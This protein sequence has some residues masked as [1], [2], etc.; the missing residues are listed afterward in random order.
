MAVVLGCSI[1]THSS[2]IKS[3]AIYIPGFQYLG[4]LL[5][6]HLE[7]SEIY[8]LLTAL[9][10]GVPV[11]TFPG[12]SKFDLDSIWTFLWGGSI[13]NQPAN[14]VSPRI[15]LCPEAVVVLL[16]MARSMIHCKDISVPEMLQNHPISIIQVL[17]QLYHNMPEFMPLFM[18][19]EVL[20]ALA[21]VLFPFSC[22]GSTDSS[23]AS[24]PAGDEN[25]TVLIVSRNIFEESPLT[26]HPV[27]QFI[28][29]FIRVVVVDSLSLSV[30]GKTAPVI[31]I[32]LDAFPE[33]STSSQQ[34]C[35]QTEILITLM[36]HLL[37]ADMLVGDQA[38]IPVVPLA[39]AHIQHVTPNVFYLTARIVDKLWQGSLT[40]DPHDVFDFI[41]KLIGQAKRRSSNLSLECLYH[42][43]NRTILFLLSRSSDNI[44]D[45]MSVLEALHKL[46]T[47][48]IIVFGAGNHEL[49]FI[50]C[51]TY[52]LLQ[53]TADMRI[54]LESNM[55]TTW[56]V[57]PSSDLESRD[58]HLNTHQGRNL[59][60]GAALRVWEELYVC[61]KPAIEEVF[62]VTLGSPNQNAKAPDL[63]IV[64]E[65]VFDAATKLWLNYVDAERKATYRVPWEF[66][67]Q[68][69]SKIHKVT[70]GLTRL[71][72]RTKVRKDD[73]M[74]V[75]VRMSKKQASIW[76]INH[77]N[78][79]K[80]YI[81]M[82]RQ[83][84]QNTT[85]HTQRYVHQEWLQT[86]NELTRERGLWG[87][88]EPCY[89]DKWMLDMTEG[90]NRMRKKTM[91]N[92]LFYL[93]YP[94][95]PEHE[96]GM[97]KYKV[98]TSHHSK[99]YYQAVQR[100]QQYGATGLTEPERADS[101]VEEPSPLPLTPLPPLARL[102]SDPD[103]LQEENDTEE[104][105]SPPPD[106]QTLMRLLEENEKVFIPIIIQI[107]VFRK[108]GK[109]NFKHGP[110]THLEKKTTNF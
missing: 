43:L 23:G 30:T 32:V 71:A 92:D 28:V 38:A 34:I 47:N 40:K 74:R 19:S 102:K 48:R 63:T 42:C 72:S 7:V 35:Y 21:A 12:E 82:R 5:P 31:D 101:I 27:R 60:A 37:A 24:S 78:L 100:R 50:G 6:S 81:E 49:D 26:T 86:E 14:S 62:K 103:D 90:P 84:H 39:S 66:H 44:A 16:T 99:I 46:T 68:I 9:I 89:L 54:I 70:G 77:V 61:K 13:S 20:G 29:D 95:R 76:M 18:S 87:P 65:Q 56:H 52:C 106:N 85:Q 11:K 58:E 8:F 105:P 98:A 80:E 109:I 88:P 96:K 55:R 79:L 57:N 25:D 75:K 69:Q 51:L 104:E 64:R 97:L 110:Q 4:W 107:H 67:N 22:A 2:D 94:Y 91:R 83:Q 3:E 73:T 17:F 15:N 108:N 1:N 53:L 33:D 93:H 36:D 41:V 10:M 45:Q 59:M